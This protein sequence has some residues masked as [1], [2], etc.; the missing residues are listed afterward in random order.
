MHSLTAIERRVAALEH[1]TGAEL[2]VLFVA[3][4]AP[5]N[6]E[7]RVR[8]KFNGQAFEQAGDE[9]R[10]AFEARVTAA[11]KTNPP[12]GC[13]LAVVFCEAIHA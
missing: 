11:V 12:A 9:A 8:A 4:V 1:R 5:G 13:A 7:P 2:N 10:E 3:F 6:L